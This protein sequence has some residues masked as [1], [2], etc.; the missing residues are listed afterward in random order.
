MNV[1]FVDPLH[2]FEEAATWQN[3]VSVGDIQYLYA[4]T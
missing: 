2:L 1:H 4:E 3:A